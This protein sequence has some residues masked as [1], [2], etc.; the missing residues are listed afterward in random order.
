M[1][2]EVCAV[3][4]TAVKQCA[5]HFYSSTVNPDKEAKI[6]P[7]YMMDYG[8]KYP[9]FFSYTIFFTMYQIN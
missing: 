2:N 5:F 4:E 9:L 8:L 1:Y 7:Q 6:R 3:R